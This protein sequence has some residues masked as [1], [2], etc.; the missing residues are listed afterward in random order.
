MRGMKAGQR[1]SSMVNGRFD[2]RLGLRCFFD[3]F[4]SGHEISTYSATNY[5]IHS[6]KERPTESWRD[7][8][9]NPMSPNKFCTARKA[10]FTDE[11]EAPRKTMECTQDIDCQQQLRSGVAVDWVLLLLFLTRFVQLGLLN[12]FDEII[13]RHVRATCRW[14]GSFSRPG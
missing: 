9:I 13:W 5:R 10:R 4:S 14:F 11:T 6:S 2:R 12:T 1:D 3:I 8:I 7:R